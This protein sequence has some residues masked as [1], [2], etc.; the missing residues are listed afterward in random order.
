MTKK[1]E[2]TTADTIHTAGGWVATARHKT[3]AKKQTTPYNMA[4]LAESPMDS[5]FRICA[6]DSEFRD[7]T[8]IRSMGSRNLR[9]GVY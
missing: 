9:P 5:A 1:S 4:A 7:D 8:N 3:D 6:K 2:Q